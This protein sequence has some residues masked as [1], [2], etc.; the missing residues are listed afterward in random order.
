L[1]L[2]ALESSISFQFQRGKHAIK[3]SF[4]LSP[5]LVFLRNISLFLHCLHKESV[6]AIIR[7]MMYLR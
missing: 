7:H 5:R 4:I 2:Q 3:R 6:Y 1:Q